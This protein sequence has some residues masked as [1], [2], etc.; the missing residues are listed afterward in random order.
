MGNNG[1]IR[2]FDIYEHKLSLLQ[3]EAQRLGI[4]IIETDINDG[5]K[6]R[7]DL[8]QAADKV[9]VDAPCSGLGVVRRNPGK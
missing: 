6:Q 3:E 9:L 8:K 7:E 2:S 4:T 5:L 1:L